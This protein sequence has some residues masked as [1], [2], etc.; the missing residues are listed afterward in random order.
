[1]PPSLPQ[2][3]W[4]TPRRAAACLLLLT[5]LVYAGALGGGYILDD[6]MIYLD[7]PSMPRQTI[8]SAFSGAV[9]KFL[10]HPAGYCYYRPATVLLHSWLARG[11]A[12]QPFWLHLFSLAAHAGA[13]LAA[14]LLLSRFVEARVAFLAA[15]LFVAHPL[16]VEAVAW[17]AALPEVVAAG[18][19]FVSLF[20]LVR[21]QRLSGQASLGSKV[22]GPKPT[23]VVAALPKPTLD[24]GLWT[25]DLTIAYL[26]A[27]LAMLTKES[28][29]ALPLIA[30]VFVGW[31]AWPFFSLAAG[32]LLLRRMAVGSAAAPLPGN[33]GWEAIKTAAAALLHY[34]SKLVW[35]RPL[36]LDYNLSFSTAAWLGFFLVLALLAWLAWRWPQMRR[37]ALLL[38]LPLLPALAATLVLPS[39]GKVQDRYAYAAVLG[40][41]LLAAHLARHRALAWLIPALLVAWSFLSIGAIRHWQ[42]PEALWTN[43]LRVTPNSRN[44]V[45]GLGDWYYST[46]RFEEADRVYQHGLVLL[47]GDRAILA[48][49]AAVRAAMARRAK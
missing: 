36:A 5:A 17:M 35:P 40:F 33:V 39:Q 15:A 24:F 21:S 12:T 31:R 3:P 45:L 26:A 32:A 44:A 49:Q 13:A 37:A 28:A 9:P 10:W 43:T 38:V 14:F 19:M 48:S 23:R 8:G 4:A 47:P 18:L 20:A 30:A 1:M 41:A 11:F 2:L 22:R 42:D 34:L 16:H 46:A 25:L 7:D 6:E 29:L 27:V